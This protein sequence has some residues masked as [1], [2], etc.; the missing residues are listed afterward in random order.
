MIVVINYGMGNLHSAQKGLEKGGHEAIISGSPSDIAK[1]DGIVLPGVGAFKDC[2]DGLTNGG[3][4]EPLMAAVASGT[5]LLGI[6]VGMQMLFESSEEG[7]GSPGLGLLPGKVV[8]FPKAI[9]TGL[10]V[11]HMGWNRLDCRPERPCPLLTELSLDPYVYFVHSFYPKV[12]END[13]VYATSEYGVE[14]PAVVGRDTIFGTQFH[15]EK[16]Q[17]EGIHILKAFGDYVEKCSSAVTK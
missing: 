10:K 6:C 5:P 7:E 2:F 16:S 3:F 4:V 15:P 9:D 12:T 14:F 17:T 11:P 1:A 8:R 13:I